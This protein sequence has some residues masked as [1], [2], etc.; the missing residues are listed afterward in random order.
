VKL[1][2]GEK[3]ILLM[4][5]D[6]Y[7]RLKLKDAEFDPDFISTTIHHDHLWGF[8][9]QYNG[10]PF[11]N[12]DQP[13]EVGETCDH[14]DMWYLIEEGYK[15]LSPADQKKVKDAYYKQEP[16][17]DGW[18]G[19]H[20]PHG[21]IAHYLIE[22]LKRFEHFKGRGLNSHSQTSLPHYKAMYRVSDPIRATLQRRSLSADEII[23]I[24]QAK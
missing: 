17:F 14:L 12:T 3:L 5:A 13:P 11:E 21:G 19:N 22:Q 7:K 1:S 16:K 15:K 8:N 24:L 9:W 2:D 10:I 6:M 23:K 18:D 4:L 20:D